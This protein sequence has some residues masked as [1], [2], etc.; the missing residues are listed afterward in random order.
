MVHGTPNHHWNEEVVEGLLS[1]A[2]VQAR[3]A[4]QLLLHDDASNA[5]IS[6]AV[7]NASSSHSAN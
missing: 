6:I 1:L 2:A 5:A 7:V 4:Q 3:H